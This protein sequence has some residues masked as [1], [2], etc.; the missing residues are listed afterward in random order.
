MDDASQIHERLGRT[1]ATAFDFSPA[2]ALRAQDF[3]ELAVNIGAAVV[4]L[5]VMAVAYRMAD[6]R[7]NESKDFT[8]RQ[9]P[10]LGGLIF[11]GVV[12]DMIHIQIGVLASPS[13]SLFAG[14]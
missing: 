7:S 4:L 3:G 6:P 13:L 11:C 8:R 5:G 1:I 14:S 2:L 10:W 9:L 12:V